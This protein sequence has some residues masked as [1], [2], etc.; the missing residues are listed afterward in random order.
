MVMARIRRRRRGH[1]SVGCIASAD[2]RVELVEGGADA[3]EESQQRRVGAVMAAAK[4]RCRFRA[5]DEYNMGRIVV[6]MRRRS[7]IALGSS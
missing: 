6:G 5:A 4:C 2:A 7:A 1:S 3:E